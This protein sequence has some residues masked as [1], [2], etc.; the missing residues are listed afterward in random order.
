MA[1]PYT[2]EF[3]NEQYN[4]KYETLGNIEEEGKKFMMAVTSQEFRAAQNPR[5][6]V[7]TVEEEA[8][9]QQRT[10]I[11]YPP[12]YIPQGDIEK[13]IVTVRAKTLASHEIT[14]F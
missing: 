4:I 11:L 1:N 9:K 8:E 14:V 12:Y 3:G 13:I 5:Y 10:G 7:S 6:A 2:A